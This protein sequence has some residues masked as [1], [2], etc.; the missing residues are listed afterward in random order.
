MKKNEIG[1]FYVVATPIGNM[2]D[3]SNRAIRI[4]KEVNLILCENFNHSIKLLKYFQINTELKTLYSNSSENRFEWV[5]KLLEEGKDLALIC[6]SGT[7]GIS[8]PGSAIVR[9][10][11]KLDYNIIPI[12]GASALSTMLSISGCQVNPTVFLG[13][14]SEKES[15]KIKELE[16]YKEFSGLIVLY[17][18]VHRIIKTL[19]LIMEIFPESEIMIGR[20]LTKSHEEMIVINPGEISK[21]ESIILKGE[22]VVLINNI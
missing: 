3:I 5:I 9:N 1:F 10:L 22:F 4:L 6:D 13:F 16:K 17:E 2:E 19:K 8:D 18:S 20:E 11:R 7:P 15:K 14:L 21:L 12:P